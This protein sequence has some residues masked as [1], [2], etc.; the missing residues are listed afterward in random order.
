MVESLQIVISCDYTVCDNWMSFLCWYSISKNLPN[1]NVL[2]ACNRTSMRSNLFGW[3]K[4]CNVPFIIHQKLPEDMQISLLQQ[5]KLIGDTVL[6]VHPATVA[7]RDFEEGEYDPKTLD[8]HIVYID[9]L[10]GICCE[11]KDDK[12]FV[13][14]TYFNGWGKFVTS[15]W[16][17]RLSCPFAS[18]N[19]YLQG[20]MTVNE[21]RIGQLWKAVTPLFQTVSRG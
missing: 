20:S 5:R 9:N 10:P 1:V 2:V 18:D 19:R 14:A 4:K 7:I 8:G 3:A 15:D 12:P 6:F 21:A 11:A 13:F 16:I 17:N